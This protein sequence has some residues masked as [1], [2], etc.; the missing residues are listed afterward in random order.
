[1]IF[2]AHLLQGAF[3]KL[4]KKSQMKKLLMLLLLSGSLFAQ[5]EVLNVQWYCVDEKPFKNGDCQISGN[6]Y[7]FVF[8]EEKKKEVVFFFTDMKLKYS[9]TDS[10]P[11]ATD[12]N[13]KYYV[14][15]NETGRADMR[16]NKAKTKVEFIYPD[17]KI[18]LTVG[19][20]T[21]LGMK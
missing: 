3:S 13:Y 10:Y 16:I 17:K 11:D 6:E 5:K 9:I 20:S 21:K 1:M 7:S 4:I 19:K 18:Y 15:E 14:L 12:P 8:L 2:L